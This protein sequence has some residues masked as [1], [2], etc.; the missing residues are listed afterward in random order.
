MAKCFGAF[1]TCRLGCGARAFLERWLMVRRIMVRSECSR[2][3]TQSSFFDSDLSSRLDFP[4]KRRATGRA[5][6]ILL[7]NSVRAAK[8][9]AKC[10]ASLTGAERTQTGP[11]KFARFV[12]YVRVC[13]S[14]SPGVQ[15]LCQNPE[16]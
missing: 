8:K 16:R 13:F 9:F 12:E 15:S 10:K 3:A 6:V 14:T 5:R 4:H 1:R 11:I 2:Q 7:Q